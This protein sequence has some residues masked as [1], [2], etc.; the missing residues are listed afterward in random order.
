[1]KDTFNPSNPCME[2]IIQ[3]INFLKNEIC[4]FSKFEKQISFKFR[5][6]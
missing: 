2:S 3:K 4:I 1:M 6:Q 5:L